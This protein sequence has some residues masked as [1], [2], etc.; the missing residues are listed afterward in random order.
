MRKFF[1]FFAD[2]GWYCHCC[3]TQYSQLLMKNSN[4]VHYRW[5]QSRSVDSDLTHWH[6]TLSLL[7]KPLIIILGAFIEINEKLL[8]TTLQVCMR[9]FI[10]NHRKNEELFLFRI[11]S[12]ILLHL[13]R[14]QERKIHNVIHTKRNSFRYS[15]E[16]NNP[17][18]SPS[19]DISS[20][21][22]SFYYFFSYCT[23]CWVFIIYSK[24]SL[25]I[26]LKV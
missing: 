15:Q 23:T 22:F 21:F 7:S 4:G 18:T 26:R 20:F 2:G 6:D 3:V 19:I 10:N 11:L 5:T 13:L 16:K 24:S 8:S 9:Y 14:E 1:F 17:N 25:F 12:R